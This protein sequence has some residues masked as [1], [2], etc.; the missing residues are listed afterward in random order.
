MRIRLIIAPL[1]I[2]T[3]LNGC[4]VAKDSQIENTAREEITILTLKKR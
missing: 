4:S 1:L 3:A 2:G